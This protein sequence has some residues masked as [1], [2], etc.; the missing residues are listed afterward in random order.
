MP[1]THPSAFAPAATELFKG[2][3]LPAP[4]TLPNVLT[5]L[6]F[7]ALENFTR[8]FAVRPGER[9]L[10]LADP[11]LDPK[12]VAAIS[13]LA[14]ARGVR[15]WMVMADTTQVTEMPEEVKPLLEKADFV[16]SSWFCSIIDPFCIA[17]RKRGQ[18]W[19][20]ITYFRDL[21]LL[22]TPQARFPIDLVGE[23]IRATAARYPVGQ[24]F[25]LHFT[26][27]RGTD[28]HI[29]FTAR[30]REL[31]LRSNRWRGKMCADE[32]GAYVH[33]LPCH[34]PNLYDRTSVDNDED[35]VV[36]VNG[37]VYPEWGVGFPRPF[38]ERYG[39]VFK[40][41][42]I[43]EV[44]GHGPYAEI[45]RDMLVGGRLIELG[46]GFNPKA[47]RR[48]IYP[49]G[50][51]SPGALHYGIDLIKPSDYIRRV[52]PEWEEPPIHMD[53]VSFDSTVMAGST[54]LIEDGFL[55]ALRES[56][57]VEMA[58]RYGDAVDLLEAWP[59]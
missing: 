54:P 1:D 21:G 23:I 25:D 4:D 20:K 31:Q 58:S 27:P 34:G 3:G 5:G 24:D 10:F 33:Y 36:P 38:A 37:V 44:T 32:P 8:V 26:D 39:V 52:M 11:K 41:D 17:Q 12:V 2:R 48:E 42:R 14:R 46:C 53:L 18:R 57:V 29:G 22:D 49:A 13:G 51:N 19:V 30:M 15:P 6:H 47:P 55:N 40:D 43:T 16:V 45:L 59:D 35:L 56:A 9:M 7:E 28:L 50:S